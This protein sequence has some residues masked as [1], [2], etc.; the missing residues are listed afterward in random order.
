[1][2]HPILPVLS[3]SKSV[4]GWSRMLEVWQAWRSIPLQQCRF[5]VPRKLSSGFYFILFSY[6]SALKT[7]GNTPK[8]GLLYNSTF[9]G[10]AGPKF[11]GRIS[12]YFMCLCILRKIRREQ[13][14]HCV[15]NRLLLRNY[16]RQVWTADAR[17]GWRA[18]SI[19]RDWRGPSK[20]RWRHEGSSGQHR[21]SK[22][23]LS[24]IKLHF[25]PMPSCCAGVW[26]TSC[27]KE[28]LMT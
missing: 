12:R 1:M 14:L 5:L 21:W 11:K 9:I 26:I 19:L 4:L 17:P 2:L 22:L 18:P 8:Y 6:F 3:E 15:K 13:V 16:H 10:R 7:K 20:E 27:E 23:P 28:T 24:F 25:I